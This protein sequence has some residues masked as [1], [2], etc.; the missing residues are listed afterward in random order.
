[1]M[2]SVESE[3]TYLRTKG[4]RV[5]PQR[6][7]VL[8]ILHAA[9]GHLQAADIYRLA[10]QKIPGINE[11]TVYRTVEFL[12]KEGVVNRCYLDGSQIAY[13]IARQHH[14]LVCRKCGADSKI[15]HDLLIQTYAKVEAQSGYQLDAGHLIFY[16][17]CP[18]CQSNVH[19]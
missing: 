8:K 5:T 14:H 13:E 2:T 9:E 10:A 17:L 7:A 6:I 11:A 4:Y 12:A 15:K 16:G 18:G 19:A 1:M 3:I